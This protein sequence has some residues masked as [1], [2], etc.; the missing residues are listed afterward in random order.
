MKMM[1]SSPSARGG[2]RRRHSLRQ[3]ETK[4]VWRMISVDRE[5]DDDDVGRQRTG[6]QAR[7]AA[8]MGL[9]EGQEIVEVGAFPEVVERLARKLCTL[10]RATGEHNGRA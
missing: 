8:A 10:R 1:T 9:I 7:A 3:R 5:K 4:L 2:R 6:E